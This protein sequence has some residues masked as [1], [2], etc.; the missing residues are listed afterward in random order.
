MIYMISKIK[1]QKIISLTDSGRVTS[2]NRERIIYVSILQLN[3][4]ENIN[5]KILV[6]LPIFV[7]N[8]HNI[9]IGWVRTIIDMEA[10]Q[11]LILK[12]ILQHYY[13]LLFI[14]KFEGIYLRAVVSQNCDN[15]IIRF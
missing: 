6:N 8:F 11:E 13:G 9:F 10:R 15:D 7:N 5:N 4:K 1:M 12:V 14:E 3:N 2:Y